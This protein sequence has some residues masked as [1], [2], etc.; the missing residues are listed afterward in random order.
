MP[1]QLTYTEAV[2]RTAKKLGTFPSELMRLSP[3]HRDDAIREALP[4][5]RYTILRPDGSTLPKEL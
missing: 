5:K 1:T 3:T 4:P 2:A